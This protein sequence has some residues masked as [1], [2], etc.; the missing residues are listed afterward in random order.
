[1]K[2][3][4]LEDT[5]ADIIGKAQRGLGLSDSA[6]AAKTGL[7]SEQIRRAREGEVERTILE[8][9]GPAL[10]LNREALIA[11][12][13]GAW[14]N[15]PIPEIEGLAGVNTNFG[16]MSVNAYLVWDPVTREAVAF[17]TG[18]DCTPILNLTGEHHL[19]VKLILLTHAHPDHVADLGR[20]QQKT[21]APVYI[22]ERETTEGA[23]RIAEGK[24]F[25]VG[26]LKIEARL[27]WGHS[28]GGMTYVI[29]GLAGPIAV[30]GDSLFAGSMGGGNV[31]YEEAIRN[32][33][34]KILTLPDE[35]VICPGHGPMT[36]VGQEKRHNPFFAA[37]M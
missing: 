18:A 22:S 13:E 5:V 12:A 33:R 31:S 3:I 25:D 29:N 15:N 24:R 10:Q 8:R 1:M 21:G 23:Q 32:N 26:K 37:M 2:M 35:T 6:L 30:V 20:L 9:L 36:T 11:L 7:S 28:P 16:D 14:K 17:D 19:T 34:E 27:T 4:P